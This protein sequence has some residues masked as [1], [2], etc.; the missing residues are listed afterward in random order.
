MVFPLF[1]Y[2]HFFQSGII[3]ALKFCVLIYIEMP[4]RWILILRA[5]YVHRRSK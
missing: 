4:L 1:G 3:L 2:E 5:V